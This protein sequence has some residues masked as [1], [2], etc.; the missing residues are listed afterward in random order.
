MRI[1][2]V[3]PAYKESER[4]ERVLDDLVSTLSEFPE[5]RIIVVDDGS[6]DATANIVQ[7]FAKRHPKA[8]LT[9]LRHRTNLGKGAAAKSGCEASTRLGADI[10]V[11]MDSDGQ[12]KAVDV[13]KLLHVLEAHPHTLVIGSRKRQGEMPLMMRLGNFSL[14]S[15]ASLLYGIKTRDT[16]SGLRAFY[17]EDYPKLRWLAMHYAMETEMLIFAAH[18][19]IP[20]LEVPIQTIYHDKHKGTTPLD[21]IRIL[22]LLISWRFRLLTK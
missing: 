22:L 17:T 7:D 8:T 10:T 18:N 21:G 16:Q 5:L 13:A 14:S 1:A 15:L 11:L 12:H 20:V 4:I 6:P 3:L 9:L 2:V 19:H